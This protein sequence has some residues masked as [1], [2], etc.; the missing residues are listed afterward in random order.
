MSHR[1]PSSTESPPSGSPLLRFGRYF[2][3]TLLGNEMPV[4]CTLVLLGLGVLGS[5]LLTPVISG[6]FE[7]ASIKSRY[8]SDG[9]RT[10]SA[11]TAELIVAVRALNGNLATS[12]DSPATGA[13]KTDV[14]ARL[15]RLKWKAI[16]LSTIAGT[17]GEKNLIH[18]YGEALETL[19]GTVRIAASS[20]S[21]E[22][23]DSDVAVL[24]DRTYAVLRLLAAKADLR[25]S[26]IEAK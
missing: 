17:E 4:W 13:T 6:E 24:V 20:S 19:A 11:D 1:S 16:E 22:G 8:V 23:I 25:V 10:L 21:T 2:G 7:A 14:D 15:T 18:A 3:R 5:Y 9:L 26:P 12:A